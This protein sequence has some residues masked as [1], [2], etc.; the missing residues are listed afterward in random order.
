MASGRRSVASVE[1]AGILPANTIYFSSS[2]SSRDPWGR[3]ERRDAW[4][5]RARQTL[6]EAQ[7]VFMDPYMGLTREPA[8]LLGADGAK[9]V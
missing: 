5:A 6:S 8:S 4:N 2:L 1:R 9:Y 7:L 3:A